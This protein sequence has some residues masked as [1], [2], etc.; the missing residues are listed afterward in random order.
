MSIIYKEKLED[1]FTDKILP[2]I[3][4]DSESLEEAKTRVELVWSKGYQFVCP[5]KDDLHDKVEETW[6][7]VWEKY[8]AK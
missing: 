7:E 4:K 5:N 2:D 8:N 1:K 3:C 6:N